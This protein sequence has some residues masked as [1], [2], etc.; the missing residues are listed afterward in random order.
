MVVSAPLSKDALK[1]DAKSTADRLILLIRKFVENAKLKR[2]VVGMSGGVDSSV[3]AAL[4]AKALG[5]DRVIGVALP[6]RETMNPKDIDDAYEVARQ[7]DI[8]FFIVDITDIL[9]AF[10]KS[11]EVYD[12]SDRV[13]NGNLKARARMMTLYYFAN[14]FGAL[15]VGTSNKSEILT[16]YFTKYG[17][18]ASDLAP[19]GDLYKAQGYQLARYLHLPTAVIEKKPTAGLWPG[20]FD[21]DELGVTYENLDLI[22]HGLENHMS[23]SVIAESLK[24]SRTLVNRVV[25]MWQSSEHKRRG[26]VILSHVYD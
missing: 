14:H 3:T 20:Q 9:T 24:I 25:E 21:E 7:F 18:G 26:P 15:V 10:E 23:P 2:S 13:S 8:K 11:A 12:R 4:C 17:D 22:L 19:L 1:I 5:K 16:G 6:E